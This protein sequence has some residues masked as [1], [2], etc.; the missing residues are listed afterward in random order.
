MDY[1]NRWDQRLRIHTAGRDESG[2]DR[3]HHPYEPTPYCVLERLVTGGLI[4]EK[5]TVIDYG[6]GK[7]RVGLFLA[8][9]T[10]AGTIGVEYDERIYTQALENQKQR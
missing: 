3:Y 2:A 6:S 1:E 7:G 5:D 10:K 8:A 9:Q 4:G